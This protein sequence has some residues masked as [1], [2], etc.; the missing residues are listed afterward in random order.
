MGVK[1]TIGSLKD[2]VTFKK[3]VRGSLGAGSKDNY[4]EF[5][6]TRCSL[7]KKRNVRDNDR[8]QVELIVWYYMRC[9]F[10]ESLVSNLAYSVICEIKGELY[11]L[12]DFD[13]I[14]RKN[15][16]Y[17]FTISKPKRNG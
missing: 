13:V 10:Q 1:F 14:D 7:E 6:T 11:T 8:G 5:L 12:H 17:E 4:I 16:L 15:H 3:N 2:K 9:R